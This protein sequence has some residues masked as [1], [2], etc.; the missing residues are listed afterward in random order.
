MESIIWFLIIGVLFYFMMKH[1]C[2]A[3]MGGHGG[4][5]TH[6]GHEERGNAAGG[7]L[8]ASQK[9]K[10]PVCGMEIDRD[11][12]N[13]MIRKGDRQLYFCSEQCA[14]KFSREPEKYL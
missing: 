13:S 8:G 14:D 5:G 6:G 1:G 2:G 10:D 9:V 4:H 7:T 3:H 11:Q 12:A